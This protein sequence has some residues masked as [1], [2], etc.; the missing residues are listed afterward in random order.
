MMTL[1]VIRRNVNPETD[2]DKPLIQML[3]RH[4]L[5]LV[6]VISSTLAPQSRCMA[7]RYRH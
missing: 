6:S 7:L 1:V 3:S 2:L 4:R 5:P